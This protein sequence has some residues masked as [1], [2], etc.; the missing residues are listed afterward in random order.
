MD[1]LQAKASKLKEEYI[2]ATLLRRDAG[3]ELRS[4]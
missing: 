1:Q 3:G 4:I 2:G